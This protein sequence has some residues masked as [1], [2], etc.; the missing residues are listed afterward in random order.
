MKVQAD[1][2]DLHTPNGGLQATG[3]V[4]VTGPCVEARCE[5]LTIA[6]PT[7]QVA[8]DGGVRLAFQTKGM[9]QEM[10]AESVCFRLNGTN[11]PVDFSAN[12]VRKV[13]ATTP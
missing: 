13:A 6:W 3:R 11:Q 12:D 10:R 9:V 8:L 4:A 1:K 5:R 2:I 7:G